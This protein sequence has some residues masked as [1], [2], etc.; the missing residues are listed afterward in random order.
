VGLSFPFGPFQ[1]KKKIETTT[2]KTNDARAHAI[3]DT[4]LNSTRLKPTTTTATTTAMA[5]G[6]NKKILLRV[7]L[8]DG[9]H[10]TVFV[11]PDTTS[12]EDLWRMLCEKLGLP[13]SDW[14]CF[15][16]WGISEDL[17]LLM[18]TNT[19][20]ADI[21]AKWPTLKREFTHQHT[22]GEGQQRPTGIM[23]T[24]TMLHLPAGTKSKLKRSASKIDVGKTS[25]GQSTFQE[26]PPPKPKAGAG[27]GLSMSAGATG[28]APRDTVSMPVAMA[29]P[30]LRPAGVAAADSVEGPDFKLV[31]K[32]TAVLPIEAEV[33][34]KSE[35]A[36]RLFYTKAVHDTVHSNYP[37]PVKMAVKLAGMQMQVACG[38][39]NPAVHKPGFLALQLHEYVPEHL[40]AKQ[41]PEWWEAS[42]IQEH[43]AHTGKARLDVMNAYLQAV[44]GWKAYGS[45]FF[46]AK[47]VPSHQS[48]F[49]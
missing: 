8:V 49:K 37:T 26:L 21:I 40:R 16:L 45:T 18:Y 2:T 43:R 30:R 20:V 5:E 22:G 15:F 9:T 1:K 24:V 47:Y 3:H 34:C 10:K 11:D 6:N 36:A 44:R 12:V 39:A 38:D 32:P 28:T 27:A 35:A 25:S 7:H 13:E 41:K 29:S 33:L 19:M 42:I 46:K 14:E 17:E 31:F 4:P 23:R 48:F